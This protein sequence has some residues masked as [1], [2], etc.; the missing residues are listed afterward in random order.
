MLNRLT[1]LPIHDVYRP[2]LAITL[3]TGSSF[4]TGFGWI[5]ISL[6]DGLKISSKC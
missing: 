1:T 4:G 5:E 3:Y 2:V 6:V